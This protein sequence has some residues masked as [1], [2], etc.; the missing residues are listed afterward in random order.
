MV[1]KIVALMLIMVMMIPSMTFSF[2]TSFT[3]VTKHWAKEEIEYLQEKGII[4]GVEKN[5]QFIAMPDA[6]VTRAQY[7]TMLLAS[8]GIAIE[9]FE[10]SSFSDVKNDYWALNYIETAKK[11][12]IINGYE[13]HTFKPNNP[14]TRA[15][16]VTSIV[17]A[18]NLKMDDAQKKS[19]KLSFEDIDSSHWAYE[20]IKIA[21]ANDLIKGIEMDKKMYFKPSDSA[22][23]AQAMV[24]L[25]K[26]MKK[27]ASLPE[28]KEEVAK[29]ET[30]DQTSSSGGGGGGSSSNND[31][32][33]DDNNSNTSNITIDDKNDKITSFNQ[34]LTTGSNLDQSVKLAGVELSNFNGSVDDL[35][36]KPLATSADAVS[37]LLGT[38]MNGTNTRTLPGL[39]GSV[40]EFDANG[41]SFTSAKLT[42]DVAN[43]TSTDINKLNAVYYNETNQTF[44]FLPTT[45]DSVNKQVSFTTTHNSK[46]LLID[47]EKWEEQWKK[48]MTVENSVYNGDYIDFAF[49]IDSSGSMHSNDRNNLRKKAVIDIAKTFNFDAAKGTTNESVTV[50]TAVY[51]SW[52]KSYT[53]KTVTNHVYAESDRAAVI[54]FDNRAKILS[55][56][57]ADKQTVENAVYFI[58]SSNGTD[59][60]A[61]IE[62]ATVAYS[63]YGKD[64]QRR[65]AILL[66]DGRNGYS[67]SEKHWGM[68][69]D[70]SEKGITIIT[71]GLGNNL[72]VPLL[73]KIAQLSGGQYYHISTAQDIDDKFNYI[74]EHTQLCTDTDADGINDIYELMGIRLKN[75]MIVHTDPNKADTD[76][77][78][79]NDGAELGTIKE[80]TL[81]KDMMPPNCSLM[82]QKIKAYDFVSF[83]DDPNSK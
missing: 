1:K 77:D 76:G 55:T 34:E 29:E 50:V 19:L 5:G 9:K 6:L 4:K 47:T 48:E 27:E 46:Y 39:T 2:A 36:F 42:F 63:V 68:V 71:M 26:H 70:A 52:N 45:V 53:Y 65:I 51:G 75:G 60:F 25:A 38:E 78:G 7:V 16:M 56:F 12:K 64:K 21:V 43:V 18:Y 67:P 80:I 82:G 30:Q 62:E 61:G 79:V 72:D 37:S 41:K 20:Y 32:D 44:E 15:E 8:K 74:K 40:F 22:T 17:N 81:T 3:D 69:S 28:K 49:I 33:D 83:P 66:T 31:D 13:D 11:N 14:M 24:V 58:D 57:T 10:K 54:D 73:K 35:S 23:R 59:I